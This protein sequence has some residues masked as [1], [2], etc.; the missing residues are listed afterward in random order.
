V[1]EFPPENTLAVVCAQNF[2]R[3][4]SFN[5][6]DFYTKQFSAGKYLRHSRPPAPGPPYPICRDQIEFPRSLLH[7]ATHMTSPKCFVCLSAP[8]SLKPRF[9]TPDSIIS[10]KEVVVCKA[11]FFNHK[12]YQ[13]AAAVRAAAEA[14]IIEK[15]ALRLNFCASVP[16][17]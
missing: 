14:G 4:L 10:W 11:C 5:D 3:I 8:A 16:M 1:P 12:S 13:T 2:R 6:N 7:F 15:K 17:N 9:L